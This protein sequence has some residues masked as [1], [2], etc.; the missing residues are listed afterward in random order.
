MDGTRTFHT[1]GDEGGAKEAVAMA[2]TVGELLAMPHLQ[3]SLH[4]GAGGV[5]REVSWVHPSDLP[6]PWAWLSAGELLLT[7]GTGLAA[8]PG[9]QTA[10]IE[11]LAE[12][13][14][15]AF[16][17][18][19]GMQ[20]PPLTPALTD[21][22]DELSLPVVSVPYSV[23]FSAVVRA[24]AEVNEREEARQLAGVARLYSLLRTSMASGLP[25]PEMFG[26]LGLELKARL[27]LV[28]P[29]TGL[30]LFEDGPETGFAR[31]LVAE[32]AAHGGAIPGVLR[33][34]RRATDGSGATIA[35]AVAVPGDQPTALV[36]E[37]TGEQLPSLDLLQH[38]ATVGALE[39][40]QLTAD[41]DSRRRRG[42]DLLRHLLDRG[43]DPTTAGHRLAETGIG[44]AAAVL[45]LTPV[46]CDAT[47]DDV[48][49][50]LSRL[51]VPHLLLRRDD[52]L[53]ILLE[54]RPE[55]LAELTRLLDPS[56]PMGVSD[57]IGT[58]ERVPEAGQEARWALGAAEAENR[59][60]VRYG[61]ETALPLL[62]TP[63]EAR[64]LAS[65]VL[66]ALL[67]HDAEHGTAYLHTLRVTLR[68]NRSWQLAADELHIHKQTLGYRLRKI[69]QLTG[70]GVSRTDHIAELWFAV[71]AHDLVHGGTRTA[72]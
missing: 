4:A 51:R 7:N 42:T 64:V 35:L 36:A 60:T 10:F 48:D 13:G 41:R 20:G 18:G 52:S 66:G 67:A 65:R 72:S 5:D 43:L 49:R 58:A 27:Y 32:Y 45:V 17:L 62:R 15:S 50:R 23:P 14:T 30:S 70:R 6:N 9:A 57:R 61:D 59:R 47:A 19:L 40:T 22:A 28:D 31:E 26:R 11:R 53:H 29:E 21:R 39:L 12:A 44:P 56:A 33:L 63:A 16:G 3:M 24:V 25:G 69:E 37:P 1:L 55:C 68:C 38:V 8:D 71:R 46:A 54:D 2:V 34:R